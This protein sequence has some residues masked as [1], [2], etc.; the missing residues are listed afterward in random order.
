MFR[1]WLQSLRYKISKFRNINLN[2]E[3]KI[4]F[5]SGIT[6]DVLK[7]AIKKIINGK[8]DDGMYILPFK[9][10]AAYEAGIIDIHQYDEL[11]QEFQQLKNR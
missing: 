4:N 1:Y 10:Y 8:N 5:K 2:K 11:C 7:N 9:A 3:I 6:Y